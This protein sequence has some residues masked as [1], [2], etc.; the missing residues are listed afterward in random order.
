MRVTKAP[1]ERRQEILDCAY[2]LFSTHGYKRMQMKEISK[3]LGIAHGLV[4]HYF[5]SK[6]D[7]FDA[8]IS[9]IFEERMGEY[10]QISEAEVAP[11]QKIKEMFELFAQ[12][13]HGQAL[14]EAFH[15]DENE[16]LRHKM[17]FK[18]I[19]LLTPVLAQ[20]IKDGCAA[21]EFTTPY[22]EE[23]AHFLLHGELGIKSSYSGPVENLPEILKSFYER[24]L[25]ATL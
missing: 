12:K 24:L 5:K 23:T 8:V 15:S 7:L 6:D 20:I 17:R 1:D 11:R 22:P 10:V 16:M 4:Y 13:P 25:G 14:V 18:K 9:R 2:Q 21:G 3:A 19:E